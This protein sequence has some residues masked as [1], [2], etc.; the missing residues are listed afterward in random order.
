MGYSKGDV[1]IIC[2]SNITPAK[3][4]HLRR[5]C[6]LCWY[7]HD[8]C[9]CYAVDDLGTVMRERGKRSWSAYRG[10]DL[11]ERRYE[12]RYKTRRAAVA[13]LREGRE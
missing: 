3:T 8:D 6:G 12:G 13:A 1:V 10:S 11:M 5:V 9:A 2:S 4:G 7:V